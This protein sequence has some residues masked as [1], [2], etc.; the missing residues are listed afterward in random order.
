MQ[1]KL[2]LIM[3]SIKILKKDINFVLADIIEEIY[4]KEL[5]NPE[6]DLKKSGALIDEAIVIFDALIS[7]I[8]QKEVADIKAHFKAISSELETQGNALLEKLNAL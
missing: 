8:H 3:A 5:E 4:V 6:I 7:K 2:F 1:P